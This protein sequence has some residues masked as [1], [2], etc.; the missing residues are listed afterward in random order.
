M[1]SA[2]LE[3]PRTIKVREVPTPEPA[4]GELLVKVKAALT[5][6]TDLKAYLRGHSLIPMPGPFGHEFS[7][8]IAARGRGAGR[9]KVNDAV[10]SVHS[11]PCLNCAYCAKGL[12]NLCEDLMSSK[13]LG[14]FS[15]YI[16]I[17]RTYSPPECF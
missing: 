6:G 2:I 16:L 1:L 8:V 4:E 3:R 15:E 5:C 14:A 17:P 13:V 7:G 11:A 12:F 10:M 9:F